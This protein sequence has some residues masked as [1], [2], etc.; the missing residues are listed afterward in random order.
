M[1]KN[2]V[3]DFSEMGGNVLR[4]E[5]LGISELLHYQDTTTVDARTEARITTSPPMF[6]DRVL[7]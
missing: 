5:T 4:Y 6:Y 3:D 2:Y 1:L 7:N